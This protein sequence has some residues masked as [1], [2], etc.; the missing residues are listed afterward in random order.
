MLVCNKY[1]Y[2]GI[3]KPLNFLKRVKKSS[4][5]LIIEYLRLRVY[6]KIQLLVRIL[7][8]I[9]TLQVRTKTFENVDPSNKPMK[10]YFPL[11]Y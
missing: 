5:K 11:N 6:I 4:N 3:E 10:V 1:K 2:G 8:H 7:I 9:R